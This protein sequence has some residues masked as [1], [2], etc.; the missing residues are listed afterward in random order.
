MLSAASIGVAPGPYARDDRCGELTARHE[1][2][3]HGAQAEAMVHVERQDGHRQAD[4]KK[5]HKDGAHDGQQGARR[6]C[7][8]GALK[9][10]F[11]GEQ[12]NARRGGE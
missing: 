3:D 1:P 7:R 10:D 2:D 5:R 12:G 8:C 9:D 4:D 11:H 6:D